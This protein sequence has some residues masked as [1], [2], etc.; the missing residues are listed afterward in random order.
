MNGFSHSSNANTDSAMSNGRAAALHPP[1]VDISALGVTAA[2]TSAKTVAAIETACS[3]VGLFVATC[4]NMEPELERAFSAAQHFFGLAES[5]KDSV[6]RINRYGYVPDRIEARDPKDV[7][8]MGR[9]SLT[10]EY[11][12][13]GLA[14]EVDLEAIERLG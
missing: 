5:L 14:D 4:H 8:Y 9:S 12:D 10:A 7:A 3:T 11:L 1:V 2:S 6:P 13:I